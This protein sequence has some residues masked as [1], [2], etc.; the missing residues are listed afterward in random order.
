MSNNKCRVAHH[1][2]ENAAALKIAAPE[3]RHVRTAVLLSRASEVGPASRRG[4]AR[5]EQRAASFDLRREDLVLEI[6]LLDPNTLDELGHSLR[7][8]DVSRER[9][10]ARDARERTT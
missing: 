2:V 4:A 7:L 5:P 6:T 8:G 9:F 3:P 10:F 1:V